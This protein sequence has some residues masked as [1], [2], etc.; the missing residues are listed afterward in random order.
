MAFSGFRHKVGTLCKYPYPT[1]ILLLIHPLLQITHKYG[2]Y[3]RIRK[4]EQGRHCSE[5]NYKQK[6]AWLMQK[7]NTFVF[8][9]M[10]S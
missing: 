7:R 10:I 9:L 4:M 2:F 3:F 8:E 5:N 6:E 1:L